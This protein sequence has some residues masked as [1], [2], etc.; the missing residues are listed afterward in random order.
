MSVCVV[1][2]NNVFVAGAD[3]LILH[4]DGIHWIG[5]RSGTNNWLRRIWCIDKNNVFAVGD[6]GTILHY[7]GTK[8]N[9][10]KSGTDYLL[11]G[12]WG[13]KKDDIYVVGINSNSNY[14]HLL[15]HHTEQNE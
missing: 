13:N 6:Y 11:L 9:N 15:V 10:Q 3:G 2:S 5:Q 14:S 7:D 12:I 8:W 4:Y 1:N